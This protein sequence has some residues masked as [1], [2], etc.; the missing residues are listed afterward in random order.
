[1]RNIS[2]KIRKGLLLVI[3]ILLVLPAL[4][5]KFHFV[6]LAPLKG[7][8]SEP[9]KEYLNLSGWFSGSYQEGEEKYLNNS[10]GFRSWFIRINN[11]LTFSLFNKAKA[12][13]V[14]VGKKNYLFEEN[15]IKAYYGKDFIGRDSIIHRMQRL[16]FIQDTLA[17]LNKDLV[18]IFAAGK[19]SFFP[20]YF[21]EKYKTEKGTTNYETYVEMVQEFEIPHIDF[22]RYFV[23]NKNN[24][25]YPLYPQYGIHWSY[26]GM[27]LA[28]DSI[29]HFIENK[30]NIDMP[31]LYWTKVEIS[32]PKESDYDI[33]DGMNI[34]NRLKSYDMAYPDF[35]IESDSGKIK[36]S[37]LVISDSY[38][39]GMY[40]FGITNAFSNSHFW[41][42]N[43]QI[44]PDSYQSPLET[45]QVDLKE[46]IDQ[47]DVF[48]LMA[49]EATLPEFGWGFIE[50]TF[51]LFKGNKQSAEYDAEFQ[52]KVINLKNYIRTDKKWMEQIERKANEKNVSVD[53]MLTLDAI[54]QIENAE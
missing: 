33:A 45:N 36:P 20:E 37:I 26:Y 39:W 17:K 23:E 5:S 29:I 1:M 22:N 13:G 3:L 46:E 53:S 2:I 14:V 49:T 31:D 52:Q 32:Q 21:P 30:R 15:Y 40:N 51:N 54:W 16:K 47:H 11:Q 35:K 27:G 44:Y 42:Y 12:N 9:E 25:E 10:F 48:V 34:L 50:N 41:F 18:V 7:A 43:R 4:Q 6:R 19:G 8:I 24:K 38:Y 28:A